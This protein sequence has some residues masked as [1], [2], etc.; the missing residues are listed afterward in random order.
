MQYSFR[1]L[2]SARDAAVKQLQ[3]TTGPTENDNIALPFIVPGLLSPEECLAI[4]DLRQESF[5]EDGKVSVDGKRQSTLRESEIQW[6]FPGP[7]TKWIFDKVETAIEKANASYKFELYGFFQGAQVG[8]YH[9]GGFY[10]WHPD[11]GVGNTSN[12]KLSISVILSRVD[13]FTGGDLLFKCLGGEIPKAQ[14]T[15]IIFPSYLIH[16]VTPVTSGTRISLVSW[17]SGPPFR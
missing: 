16:R 11:M 6:L 17:I 14:G 2:K 7:E 4:R 5:K 1:L 3:G 13:E 9:E 8:T 15:A 10:G 12:R